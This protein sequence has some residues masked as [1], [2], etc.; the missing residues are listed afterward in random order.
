MH[1]RKV[2]V[3]GL[4]GGGCKIL[5][6]IS[7]SCIGGPALIA[8][9]TDTDVLASSQATSKI[10]IGSVRTVGLGTGG[11]MNLGRLAAEDDF[12]VIRGVFE[13]VDLIILVT[14][15]GG[16]TGT[17]AAPVVLKAARDAGALT[18]CF[19]VLPFEFEGQQKKECAGEGVAA[20]R[21]IADAFIV[22]PNERL[23]DFLGVSSVADSFDKADEVISDGISSVWKLI[24]QPGFINLDF[25]HLQKIVRNGGGACTFGY[26]TGTGAGRVEAALKALLEGPLLENGQIVASAKS[27][28][29][30]IVGGP[31]LTLKEVGDIMKAVSAKKQKDAELFMGTVVDNDFKE[32]L[33]VTIIASE[34]WSEGTP[35][36]SAAPPTPAVDELAGDKPKRGR[37]ASKNKDL[38]TKLKL[39]AASKGKFKDVEP[40]LLDGEDLD[41]PTFVRRNIVVER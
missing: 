30:S 32:K 14:A 33:S 29:V 9:N 18:L 22:I 38:Q 2:S 11:D 12:D 40:T 23:F 3:V 37:N 35:A 1:E 6:R 27:L 21:A 13:G 8:I 39:D 15:L 5:D 28:L 7:R 20:I 31:D 10:Q 24:M 16:G 19:A 25:A 17:G 4:G 34:N 41:I 26:G 36:A